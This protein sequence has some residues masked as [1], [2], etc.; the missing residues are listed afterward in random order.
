MT[1]YARVISFTRIAQLDEAIRIELAMT[2]VA[3]FTDTLLAVILIWLLRKARSGF[4]RSDSVVN[5]LV[6]YI[7]GSSLITAICVVAALISA[8]VAPHALVYLLFDLVIPKRRFL[9]RDVPWTRANRSSHRSILQLYARFVSAYSFRS[10]L[11]T[12]ND[13]LQA[14]RPFTPSRILGERRQ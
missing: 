14:E 1:Y 11:I 8:A 7:V 9:L 12:T 2:G 4:R 13:F 6:M 3:V 5:R 10:P